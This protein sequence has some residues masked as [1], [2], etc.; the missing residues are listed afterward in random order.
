[1]R[2]SDW[3]SDVC[4]SDL[5]GRQ[6][7]HVIDLRVRIIPVVRIAPQVDLRLYTPVVEPIRT[8]A[9]QAAGPR[10]AAAEL[11]ER[12]SI[13]REA[14]RVCEPRSEERRVG[15]E[16]SVRV[17]LGGRRIITKTKTETNI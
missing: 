10:E 17:D 6:I 1:M 13:D 4:S 2:I 14:H 9:D 5:V 15:K 11:C 16:C 12:R 3:S 8:I 7:L